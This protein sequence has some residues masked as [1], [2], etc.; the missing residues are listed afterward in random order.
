MSLKPHTYIYEKYSLLHQRSPEMSQRDGQ[1]INGITFWKSQG[2]E[3]INS[4]SFNLSS[5]KKI[6]PNLSSGFPLTHQINA[7]NFYWELII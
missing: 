7:L 1:F 5:Q 6:S 3:N 4:A 2:E